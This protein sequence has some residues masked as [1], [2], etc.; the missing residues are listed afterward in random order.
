MLLKFHYSIWKQSFR[1]ARKLKSG[2][3]PSIHADAFEKR[4]KRART[5]KKFLDGNVDVARIADGINLISHPHPRGF[6]EETVGRKFKTRRHVRRN[7]VRPRVAVIVR[8]VADDV[9]EIRDE[10]RIRRHGKRNVAQNFIRERNHIVRISS[11]DLRVQG[12][13][14]QGKGK[15]PA[16]ARRLGGEPRGF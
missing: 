15:L 1:N 11:V 3:L 10:R 5:A 8:A 14:H 2:A 9:A 6:V 4:F 7:R 13:I 12:Q 16:I